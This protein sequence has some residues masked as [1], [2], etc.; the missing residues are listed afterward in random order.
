MKKLHF[1]YLLLLFG[2]ACHAQTSFFIKPLTQQKGYITSHRNFFNNY[3]FF[4]TTGQSSQ[5]KYF[6]FRIKKFSTREYYYVPFG[7]S[8][9]IN[10]ETKNFI[11]ELGYVQDGV[12]CSIELTELFLAPPYPD[13]PNTPV[14]IDQTRIGQTLNYSHRIFL[15][16]SHQL[17][18]N[19]K[20]RNDFYLHF[21]SSLMF[22]KTFLS[23]YYNIYDSFEY[24]NGAKLKSTNETIIFDGKPSLMLGAGISTDCNV[25]FKNRK[26]YLFS[27][28][29]FYN[30]GFRVI[31]SYSL[32]FLIEDNGNLFHLNY[33]AQSKGSGVYF[34][35]S[36]R[37]Q[38]YPR[39]NPATP[40][41]TIH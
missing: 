11:L 8:I 35:L 1:I 36:R 10:N 16:F 29:A 40:T 41:L 14:Y 9:G 17:F 4:Y 3:G 6:D 15:D 28:G 32:S 13:Q 31:G 12:G 33:G 25:Y 34:E 39:K 19:N 30:H 37:F 7:I 24:F 18:A 23:I 27:L 20:S 22:G 5:N 21:V 26:K 38:L 2:C